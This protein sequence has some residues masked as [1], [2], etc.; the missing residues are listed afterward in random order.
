M[1]KDPKAHLL[2]SL[3][4]PIRQRHWDTL[5]IILG[6]DL[7]ESLVP[8]LTPVNGGAT[9]MYSILRKIINSVAVLI[10]L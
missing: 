5:N 8:R 9:T 3:G 1:G 6:Y 2:R 7:I 4:L 10:I